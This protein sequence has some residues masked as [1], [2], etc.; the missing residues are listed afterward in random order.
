MSKSL[1][2]TVDSTCISSGYCRRT[3]PQVFTEGPNRTSVVTGNPVTDSEQV[4]EA[5]EGCPVE[6]ISAVDAQTGEQ[7]F[8]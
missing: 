4:R 5:M 3:A 1:N 7:V 2:V 8:P 6:A